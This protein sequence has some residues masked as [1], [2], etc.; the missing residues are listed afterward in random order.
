M[1]HPQT[2]PQPMPSPF[3]L[4]P[5]EPRALLSATGGGHLAGLDFAGGRFIGPSATI[6]LDLAPDA[7]QTGLA[8]LA[9]T[10]GVPAPATDATVYL[11]NRDGVETYTVKITGTGTSTLLTVDVA[12][13]ALAKATRDTTTFADLPTAASAEITKMADALDL[14]APA[15]DADVLA[16]T[17]AGGTATYT[18]RLTPPADADV[19]FFRHFGQVVTVNADGLPVGNQRLPAS[20]FPSAVVDGLNAAKPAG[21]TAIDPTGTTDFIGVRTANGVTTYSALFTATGTRTTVTVNADGTLAA[22]PSRS[23]VAFSEVPSAAQTELNALAADKGADPIAADAKVVAYDEANGTVIYS[24]TVSYTTTSGRTRYATA[25]ADQDGNAT[26]P[27]RVGFG[28]FGPGI[29]FHFGDFDSPFAGGL[30]DV[31]GGLFGHGG[32]GHGHGG[33]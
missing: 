27:P 14:A 23:T 17:P 32:H 8:A 1:S 4:E 18:V 28:A 25:S 7:V 2:Q 20:V 5:L 9:S 12:G 6:S 24:T 22:L 15:S 21:A 16:V 26:V 19:G 31:L 13:D 29:D 30:G 11:A 3:A 33:F 10:D